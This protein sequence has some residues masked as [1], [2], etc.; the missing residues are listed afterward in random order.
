M[1]IEELARQAGE[2]AQA[3]FDKAARKGKWIAFNPIRDE[4]FAALVLGQAAQKCED[5]NSYDEYDPMASCAKEIR[6][7]KPTQEG[8]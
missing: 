6:A 1:N 8:L 4:R 5:M 3:A 7:M 2:F